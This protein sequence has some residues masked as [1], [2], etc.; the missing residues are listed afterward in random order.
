MINKY[1]T[2][3][4]ADSFQL[5]SSLINEPLLTKSE[6][7]ALFERVKEGDKEAKNLII[8]KNLKL[9]IDIAHKLLMISRN[10]HDRNDLSL[11]D[12]IQEGNIALIRAVETYDP[13]LYDNSFSTFAYPTIFYLIKNYIKKSTIIHVPPERLQ[14]QKAIR[15]AE[16]EFYSKLGRKPTNE[17]LAK[18][19]DMKVDIIKDLRNYTISSCLFSE[20]PLQDNDD[21]DLREYFISS[22]ACTSFED[23]LIETVAKENIKN[24]LEVI[25]ENTKLKANDLFVINHIFGLNGCK[26]MKLTEL[27]EQLGKTHQEISRIY[28]KVM[29][30]LN[31]TARNCGMTNYTIDPKDINL[32]NLRLR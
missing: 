10:V 32:N 8:E 13:S 31:T 14:R 25:F 21:D 9:V 4:S 28:Y 26:A 20:I 11:D 17:E 5:P 24:S 1:S 12:L 30:K 7:K 19:L 22:K 16:E 2:L 15:V 6:E 3:Y 23:E 29:R 27:A 18:I